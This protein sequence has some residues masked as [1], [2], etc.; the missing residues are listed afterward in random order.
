[1]INLYA[2]VEETSRFIRPITIKFSI[3]LQGIV[4]DTGICIHVYILPNSNI[5][6]TLDM[7][8]F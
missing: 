6:Q 1:M 5:L 4:S 3:T 7:I 2:A 8:F